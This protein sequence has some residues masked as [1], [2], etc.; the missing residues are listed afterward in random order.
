MT[1][2]G[3]RAAASIPTFPDDSLQAVNGSWW[4]PDESSTHCVGRLVLAAI[5]HVDQV[6]KM[7]TPTGRRRPDI[8][9]SATFRVEEF[10]ISNYTR[11]CRLPV[12]GMPAYR[13]EVNIVQRAKRRPCLIVGLCGESIPKPENPGKPGWQTAPTLLVAPYYGVD[14]GDNRAGWSAAFVQQIRACQYPQYI[15][16]KAPYGSTKE[17]ILRMDHIQAIGRHHNSLEILP[18]RLSCDAVH[19][20]NDWMHWLRHNTVKEDSVLEVI[21]ESL[22]E[23]NSV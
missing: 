21:L 17:S 2:S 20:L 15:W 14:E 9:D 6:P 19:V 13:H 3:S 22:G 4:E 10:N 7:I 18:W 23:V 12:A 1:K 5:P 16:D 8:H 11:H